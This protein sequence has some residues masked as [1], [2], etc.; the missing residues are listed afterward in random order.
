VV[1][2]AQGMGEPIGCYGELISALT[3][4]GFTVYGNEHRGHGRTAPSPEALGDFGDSFDRLIEDV[5]RLRTYRPI[6]LA[7]RIG[8]TGGNWR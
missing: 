1:Q 7:S 5:L 4:A 3:A 6:P 2:V 8:L